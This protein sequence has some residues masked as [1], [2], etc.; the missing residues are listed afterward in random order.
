[1][2]TTYT[3]FIIVPPGYP[4]GLDHALGVID[5][6]M[7]FKSREDAESSISYIIVDNISLHKV[8]EVQLTVSVKSEEY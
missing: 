7:L 1:M 3:R 4:A 2:P 8:V 6:N 5:T